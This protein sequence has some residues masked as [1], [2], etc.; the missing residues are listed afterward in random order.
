MSN[1]INKEKK[2]K[3]GYFQAPFTALTVEHE[4]NLKVREGKISKLGQK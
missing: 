2:R 4:L 1:Y 3:T